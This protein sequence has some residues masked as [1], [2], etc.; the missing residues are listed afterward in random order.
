MSYGL[1]TGDTCDTCFLKLSVV[2][3]ILLVGCISME[4]FPCAASS[5]LASMVRGSKVDLPAP[6]G[7]VMTAVSLS[8]S[9]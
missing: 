7:A 2:Q 4:S 3:Y 1:V 8:C 6:N 9:V 5:I